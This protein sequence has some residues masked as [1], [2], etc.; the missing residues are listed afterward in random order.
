M[1]VQNRAQRRLPRPLCLL[2]RPHCQ[3][4]LR[5]KQNKKR[6]GERRKGKGKGIPTRK[7]FQSTTIDFDDQECP[8]QTTFFEFEG[9]KTQSS[10]VLLFGPALLSIQSSLTRAPG[11]LQLPKNFPQTYNIFV[12]VA[13]TKKRVNL[14]DKRKMRNQEIKS[15][16][17]KKEKKTCVSLKFK[18]ISELSSTEQISLSS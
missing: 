9:P 4:Y 18:S 13:I 10:K 1:A 3:T 7:P 14:L 16:H 5:W 6:K 8:C 2:F 17:S 15:I 12:G 11:S